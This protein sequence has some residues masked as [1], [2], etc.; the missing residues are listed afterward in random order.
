MPATF[1][2]TFMFIVSFILFITSEREASSYCGDAFERQICISGTVSLIDKQ[3]S[4]VG[5]SISP[6][7]YETNSESH[8]GTWRVP[9]EGV[10]QMFRLLFVG[11]DC[12]DCVKTWYAIWAPLVTVHAVVMGGVSLH[13]HTALLCLRN[14]STDCVQ[15]WCARWG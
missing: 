4:F 8:S 15:I 14:G 2:S 13:V 7:A 11:N 6:A 3:F 1:S 12:A 10:S 9:L 5:N